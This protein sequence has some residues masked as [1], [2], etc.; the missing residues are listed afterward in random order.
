MIECVAK[1]CVPGIG[2]RSMPVGET[3]RASLSA[4]T[5]AFRRLQRPATGRLP[6]R[7]SGSEPDASAMTEAQV[8]KRRATNP[9][10]LCFVVDR[11]ASGERRRVA[12]LASDDR[13]VAPV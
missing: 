5:C 7:D 9:P 1:A 3:K 6:L 2:E 8:I 11:S 12:S 4:A 13:V 10:T